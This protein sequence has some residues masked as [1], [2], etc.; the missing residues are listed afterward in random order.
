MLTKCAY[1][2]LMGQ[3][4]MNGLLATRMK[5]FVT[6]PDVGAWNTRKDRGAPHPRGAPPQEYTAGIDQEYGT[7]IDDWMKMVPYPL[8]AEL[9]SL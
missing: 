9:S 2:A 5:I 7:G 6:A 4:P 8:H 1:L 3:R